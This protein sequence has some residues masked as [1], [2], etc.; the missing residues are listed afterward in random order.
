MPRDVLWLRRVRVLRRMLKKYRK[1]F[2][3]WLFFACSD[4]SLL[5]LARLMLTCTTTCTCASRV[6]SFSS[7][8]ARLLTTRMSIG[9]VF[10]N[11]KT[12]MEHIH[13]AKN[14]LK[15]EKALSDQ[16]AARRD[17]NKKRRAGQ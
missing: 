3:R 15:R 10:K 6:S 7:F 17:R 2:A 8:I 4:S 9:N 11:K 5:R 14:E 12:L 1:V 16:A 13:K